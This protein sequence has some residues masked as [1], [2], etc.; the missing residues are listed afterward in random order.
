M[1]R[2]CTCVAI[3]WYSHLTG[4]LN[5]MTYLG[6]FILRSRKFK[7]SREHAKKLLS[8]MQRTPNAVFSKIGHV[9]SEKVTLQLINNRCLP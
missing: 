3:N 8:R 7:R 4:S 2:V 5:E 1:P 9:A 6:I